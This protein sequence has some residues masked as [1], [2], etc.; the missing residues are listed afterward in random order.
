MRDSIKNIDVNFVIQQDYS[1]R[2]DSGVVIRAVGM[3]CYELDV[4]G[5]TVTVP[6][7]Y[8]GGT[9]AYLNIWVGGVEV[10]GASSSQTDK[11]ALINKVVDTLAEYLLSR[12]TKVCIRW[13]KDRDE[14]RS[15]RYIPLAIRFANWLG[16]FHTP[17]PKTSIKHKKDQN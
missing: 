11:P 10:Q 16:R 2:S 15:P 3:R 17:R 4:D 7:D 5:I 6:V 14:W 13:A 1:I 12:S 9:E 8:S